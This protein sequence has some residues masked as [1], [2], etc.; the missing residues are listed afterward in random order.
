MDKG[1][2]GCARL[3]TVSN[4]NNNKRYVS[5]GEGVQSVSC[6]KEYFCT[7]TEGILYIVDKQNSHTRCF[8]CELE[9]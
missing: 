9:F 3:M 2:K 6:N 4:I 8:S 7:T 1:C 5:T